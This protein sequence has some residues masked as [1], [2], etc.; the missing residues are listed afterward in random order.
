[1]SEFDDL[2]DTTLDDLEDAPEFKPYPP[3]AHRVT[4][5]FDLKEISGKQTPELSFKYLELLELSD[6]QDETPKEGDTANTI[7]MM[8]NEFG[9]GSFKRCSLPFGEALG[10]KTGREIIEG[11]K[12]V[13]CVILTGIRYAKDDKKKE[14]PYLTVKQIDVV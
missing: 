3:G 5:S 1:M 2:L 13:E 14:T 12:D 10:L 9:V 11:V 6:P 7:F 8:D 4:A